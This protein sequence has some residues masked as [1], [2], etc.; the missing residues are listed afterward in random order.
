MKAKGA[1]YRRRHRR[2]R[3]VGNR[4]GAVH[5]RSHVVGGPRELPCGGR[6]PGS[7]T[8]VDGRT[9][10]QTHDQHHTP[11]GHRLE[12]E[13]APRGDRIPANRP[14]PESLGAGACRGLPLGLY[15]GGFHLPDAGV[16][17]VSAGDGIRRGAGHLRPWSEPVPRQHRGAFP[18]GGVS[19][20]FEQFPG[21]ESGKSAVIGLKNRLPNA[22]IQL[23]QN[24]VILR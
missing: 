13:I 20:G 2:K 16:G 22:T 11:F 24:A 21:M 5:V 23:A 6:V 7:M 10:P 14:V 4:A 19:P 3:T 1:V 15:P 12:T 8:A 18:R 9:E 17:K